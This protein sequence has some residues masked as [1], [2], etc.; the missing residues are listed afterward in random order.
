MF[1]LRNHFGPRL[2]R[3]V[4]VG[5]FLG[6]LAVFFPGGLSAAPLPARSGTVVAWGKNDRGQTTLPTAL[7][8]ITA[9]AAG[10][11][12]NLVLKRDGTVVTW[13]K[14]EYGQT[15][16]PAEL[17][18]VTAI[19]ASGDRNLAL[20]SDGTVVA[21]GSYLMG[22]AAVPTGLSGVMAIAA[23]D[24][25][26]LA[27]KSDGTVVAWGPSNFGQLTVPAG[28]SHVIAIAAARGT[29]WRSKATAPSSPGAATSTDRRP[30]RRVFLM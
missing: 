27:L 1:S 15:T 10:G 13:G 19:A 29:V 9:I 18:G 30:C 6:F 22:D 14:N 3:S 28:L 26:S 20:K 11:N 5:I 25:V 24:L 2:P 21:W 8:H 16:V 4:F 23:G 12:Y 17:S 7:S